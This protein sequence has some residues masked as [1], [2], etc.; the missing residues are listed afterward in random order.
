MRKNADPQLCE[1]AGPLAPMEGAGL[2]R[3]QQASQN[4]LCRALEVWYTDKKQWTAVSK[5]VMQQDWSWAD[6]ALDYIEIYY[7]A[8]K[9]R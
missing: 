9:G 6:P 5:R 7:R 8:R 4:R 1:K 3:L 2:H